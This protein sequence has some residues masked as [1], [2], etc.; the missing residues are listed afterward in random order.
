MA[1]PNKLAMLAFSVFVLLA[2]GCISTPPGPTPGPAPT[3]VATAT[4]TPT[5]TPTDLEVSVR[6][7][8]ASGNPDRAD[9]LLGLGTDAIPVYLEL[10][11]ENDTFGR[12]C[13]LYALS[14]VAYDSDAAERREITDELVPLFTQDPAS[15]RMMA[16][17]VAT[18]L[19]DKRGIPV[20]IGCLNETARFR[21]SEPPAPICYY[22]NDFLARFTGVDFDYS[23]NYD[24]YDARAAAGWQGW[25][26]AFGAQLEWDEGAKTFGV[27]DG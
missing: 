5:A 21:D 27:P 24:S 23:C 13:A 2:S 7:V 14:N 17:A 4:P 16:G 11:G 1:G 8:V 6:D 20:L 25:W 19:G 15:V 26:E 3:E 9:E 12:W 22:A 18:E 10:L